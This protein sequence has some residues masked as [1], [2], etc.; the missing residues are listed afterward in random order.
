MRHA[1]A[2]EDYIRQLQAYK[3]LENPSFS[4]EDSRESVLGTLETLSR[5]K[6]EIFSVANGMIREYIETFEKRPDAMTEE[7]VTLLTEFMERLV[8][9]GLYTGQATDFA[10]LYRLAKLLA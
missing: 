2:P 4:K 6:Q 8:P 1:Y 9:N 5:Q 3:K 7:D 10:I